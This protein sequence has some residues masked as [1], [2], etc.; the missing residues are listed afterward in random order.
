MPRSPELV[1]LAAFA[2]A[3]V[4]LALARPWLAASAGAA[5][6]TSA[7]AAGS[8]AIADAF[9][10][11]VPLARVACLPALAAAAGA[12]AAAAFEGGGLRLA[13]PAPSLSRMN[14][15]AGLARMFSRDALVGGVRSGFVFAA[16]GAALV[17]AVRDAIASAA[18]G[19]AP[20]TALDG[21]TR[22]V[23]TALAAGTLFVAADYALAR[24]RWLRQIRMTHDELRRDLR[25][26]DGD[27]V[28][29]GRRAAR[30]RALVRGGV[31]R[32]C[33][34]TFVVTNPT[35]IAIGM[36]YAP[37]AVEVPEL[38]VRATDAAAQRVK[39]LAREYRIPLVENVALARLLLA[40]GRDGAPIP[41]EAYVAVAQVVAALIHSGALAAGEP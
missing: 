17:P 7:T 4:A 14:P 22:V 6:A 20:Q 34:A 35:H 33:D 37:P 32:V 3:A 29:R 9:R 1:A 36:R 10:H 26:H 40:Q 24:I 27:P 18:R 16:V 13:L 25:E 2:C 23:A 38:V 12:V 30:H 31:A 8:D 28:L 41:R 19:A 21:V 39:E 15:V 11:V 5:F